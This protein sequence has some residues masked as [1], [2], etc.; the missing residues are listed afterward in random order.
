MDP[1]AKMV[2]LRREKNATAGHLRLVKKGRQTGAHH[3]HVSSL[4]LHTY[5]FVFQH[6]LETCYHKL[7]S[8]I[9]KIDFKS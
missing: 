4:L 7:V 3:L 8:P 5:L 9:C 2:S 1:S 6:N